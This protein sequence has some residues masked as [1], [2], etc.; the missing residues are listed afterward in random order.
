M[1]TNFKAQPRRSKAEIEHARI[2]RKFK[3][4][5]AQMKKDCERLR[6]LQEEECSHLSAKETRKADVGNWD[7]YQDSYWSEY[8]CP[9]CGKYWTGNHVKAHE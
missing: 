2:H 6:K 1:G 8:Q 7:R 9:S 4:I 3:H 5:E